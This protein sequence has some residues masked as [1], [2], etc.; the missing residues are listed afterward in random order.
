MITGAG[1]EEKTPLLKFSFRFVPS[2]SHHPF[3]RLPWHGWPSSDNPSHSS[4]RS[5]HACLQ[6]PGT[7]SAWR[8][9]VPQEWWSFWGRQELQPGS[10]KEAEGR[11]YRW[12]PNQ[13]GSP[14]RGGPARVP[15]LLSTDPSHGVCTWVILLGSHCARSEP[16][17][18][19]WAQRA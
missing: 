18:V 10:A 8:R 17:A 4:W 13:G 14:H 3:L 7:S 11:Q 9:T 2:F 15:A 16:R 1:R 5:Q 6:A 19:T 12:S